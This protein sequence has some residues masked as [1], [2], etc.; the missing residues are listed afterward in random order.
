MTLLEAIETYTD[1][2]SYAARTTNELMRQLLFYLK[3][4]KSP[5]PFILRHYGTWSCKQ[6]ST[7]PLPSINPT[8]SHTQSI[9]IPTPS[10]CPFTQNFGYSIFLSLENLERNS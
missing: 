4:V 6:L 9:L 2:K 3:V 10:W 8:D 5:I 7:N 1:I